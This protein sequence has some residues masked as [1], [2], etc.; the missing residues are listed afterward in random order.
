MGGFC[1]NGIRQLPKNS[2]IGKEGVSYFSQGGPMSRHLELGRSSNEIGLVE[3]WRRAMALRHYE[4]I[5]F[6]IKL[7]PEGSIEG[8]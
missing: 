2:G 8:R 3:G 7:W 5:T 1:S 6:S 4:E